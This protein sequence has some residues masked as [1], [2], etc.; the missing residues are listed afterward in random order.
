VR[1]LLATGLAR[2]RSAPDD[3]Q[4]AWD[5]RNSFDAILSDEPAGAP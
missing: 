3:R 4:A 5:L 1:A 2:A